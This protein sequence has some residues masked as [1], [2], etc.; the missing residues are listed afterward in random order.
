MAANDPFNFDE[1]P[2]SRKSQGRTPQ[3]RNDDED[4]R[5][6][7]PKPARR[8]PHDEDDEDER[9]VA[10]RPANRRDRDDDYDDRPRRRKDRDDDEDERPRRSRGGD[11]F[12]PDD[13]YNP[14]FYADDIPRDL[15][16]RYSRHDLRTF[17]VPLAIVLHFVTFSLYS[18]IDCGLKHGRLPLIK[19]DDFGAGKAIGF[20]FIPIFSLYWVFVFWL[21]LTDRINF[22]FKLRQ[23]DPPIPRGLALATSIF[24]VIPYLGFVVNFFILVPI[25]LSK[26]QKAANTLDDMYDDDV[27]MFG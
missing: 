12:Y 1:E 14:D 27:D 5:P 10:R 15:Q 8:P 13:V 20:L 21:R 25:M 22:Q 24:F 2:P 7:P 11:R 16:R 18:I 6:A 17:S 9:P 3:R 19:R 4:D 23:M 26:I